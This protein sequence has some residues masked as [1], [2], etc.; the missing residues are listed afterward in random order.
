[1]TWTTVSGPVLIKSD[2]VILGGAGGLGQATRRTPLVGGPT[3]QPMSR[4]R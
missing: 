2:K 1:M 3:R 4:D